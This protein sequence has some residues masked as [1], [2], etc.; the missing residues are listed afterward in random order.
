M[1]HEENDAA[2]SSNN[3]DRYTSQYSDILPAEV[4]ESD[5]QNA[6]PLLAEG[7]GEMDAMPNEYICPSEED[8]KEIFV[9]GEANI[10][11]HSGG[12]RQ[13]TAEEAMK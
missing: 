3:D 9:P 6:S 13:Q 8:L 11:H 4:I 10:Q 1:S 2:H 7:H 5:S 12:Y